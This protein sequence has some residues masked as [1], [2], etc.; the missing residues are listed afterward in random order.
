MSQEREDRP[1]TPEEQRAAQAVGA[2]GQPRPEAGFRARLREQFVSGAIDAAAGPGSAT[3]TPIPR[4][5]SPVVPLFGLAAAAAAAMLVWLGSAAPHWSYAGASG[6]SGE[7][8]VCGKLMDHQDGAAIEAMLHP[9]TPVKTTGTMQVDLQ[10]ANRLTLQAAPG[11]EFTV[12]DTPRRWFGGPAFCEVGAGEVRF[13]TGSEMPG[14]RFVIRSPLATIEVVGTT[15]AVIAGADSACVCVLDGEV[16]MRDPDGTTHA[17]AAGKRRSVFRDG[18][19]R[20]EEI[21]PME[22]MKLEMLPDPELK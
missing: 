12:P 5:R 21:L 8:W 9:G 1:M 4:R 22:R 16:R 6:E 19:V 11:A 17:V 3:V 15:F 13:A 20:E 14:S 2:L 10:L 18:A 7:V